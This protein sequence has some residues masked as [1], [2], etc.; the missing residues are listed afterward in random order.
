MAKNKPSTPKEYDR[1]G[2]VGI[3]VVKK[4]STAK[5]GKKKA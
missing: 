4:P 1:W 2:R 5:K 3:K